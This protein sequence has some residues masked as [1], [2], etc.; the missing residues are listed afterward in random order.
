MLWGSGK[1]CYVLR[2]VVSIE[3]SACRLG[4]SYSKSR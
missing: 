2:A 1:K 3:E 4:F